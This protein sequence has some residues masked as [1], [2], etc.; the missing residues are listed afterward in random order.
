MRLR[1]ALVVSALLSACAPAPIYKPIKGGPVDTGSGSLE[2]VR[3]QLQGSW[4]LTS[5]EIYSGGKRRR[6]PAAARL[7]Y[8]EFGNLTMDGEI[9]RSGAA[10]DQRPL[11]LNYSGRAVLD[12]QNHEL[13]L[14]DLVPSG[15]ALPRSV[16][17]ATSATNVRRFDVRGDVLT[18]TIIAAD[19]KPAAAS[20][21]KRQP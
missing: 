4:A 9:A 15:D 12:I 14:L 8:D 10:Q 3:R 5:Y 1:F 11:L 17:D 20:A 6:L 18:L 13:R 16:A 19:G 2:A 21:W 7:S